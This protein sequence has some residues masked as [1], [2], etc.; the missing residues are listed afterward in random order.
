MRDEEVH[1]EVLAVHVVVD[2]RA[3]LGRHRVGVEVAVVPA[4]RQE[5]QF[6]RF[7]LKI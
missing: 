5:I 7:Y 4:A 6:G 2:H 3:D 1:G